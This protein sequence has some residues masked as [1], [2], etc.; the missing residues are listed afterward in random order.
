MPLSWP[1]QA[2]KAMSIM[3]QRLGLTSK[4][5]RK[6]K[7]VICN[8]AQNRAAAMSKLSFIFFFL[9]KFG[10]GRN[11]EDPVNLLEVDGGLDL[12]LG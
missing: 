1:K 5:S 11:D 3:R 2:V 6:G 12:D 8:R 7:T 10:M 4:R 9:Y